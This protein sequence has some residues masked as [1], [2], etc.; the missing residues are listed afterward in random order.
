V[1]HVLLL[2]YPAFFLVAPLLLFLGWRYGDRL[3]FGLLVVL[4]SFPLFQVLLHVAGQSFGYARFHLYVISLTVVGGCYLAS[5]AR[6]FPVACRLGVIGALLLSSVATV[7][8][9][10][11]DDIWDA[12]EISYYRAIFGIL[13]VD[14]FAPERDMANTVGTVLAR[15]P[16]ARILVDD[17]PGDSLVVIAAAFH[18]VVS[19]RDRDFVEALTDPAGTV[20]YVLVSSLADGSDVVSQA[21]AAG[22]A[23]YLTLVH[24]TPEALQRY[25]GQEI[26]KPKEWRLY[27]VEK[28][29]ATGS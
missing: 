6:T 29:Q 9:L 23:P 4:T 24:E 22:S 19:S 28:P 7:Q 17:L 21:T 27:Q 26:A 12:N 13:A 3:A 10:P 25:D 11:D 18:N 1:G 2:L 16:D 15:S 8:V 20:D 5:R 14:R